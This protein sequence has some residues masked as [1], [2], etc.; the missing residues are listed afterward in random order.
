[1]S[2]ASP[3][4]EFDGRYSYPEVKLAGR[5]DASGYSQ[6]PRRSRPA[7]RRGL[8]AM[9]PILVPR[10]ELVYSSNIRDR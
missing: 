8:K 3:K 9:Q 4:G 1:M 10:F 5:F 2:A 6:H 7:T